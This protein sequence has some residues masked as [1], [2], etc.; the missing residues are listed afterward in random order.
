MKHKIVGAIRWVARKRKDHTMS[1]KSAKQTE[2]LAIL[3]KTAPSIDNA[4]KAS[5]ISRKLGTGLFDT[6]AILKELHKFHQ[7]EC[8]ADNRWYAL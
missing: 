3:R 5:V 2:A 4:V 6:W 1:D 8:T 7:A